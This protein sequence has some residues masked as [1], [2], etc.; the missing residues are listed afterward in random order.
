M[1]A[2]HVTLDLVYRVSLYEL[3]H[4]KFENCQHLVIVNALWSMHCTI[5]CDQWYERKPKKLNSTIHVWESQF[6]LLSISICYQNGFEFEKKK[7]VPFSTFFYVPFLNPIFHPSNSD[8]K[9][10]NLTICLPKFS[11]KDFCCYD[12]NSCLTLITI[13]MV[14]WYQYIV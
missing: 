11:P 4:W 10:K 13:D 2:K 12:F 8:L 5:Q 9:K 7:F 14:V 6:I 3:Y 1:Q